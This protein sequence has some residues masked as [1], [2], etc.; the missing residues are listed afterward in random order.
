MW[1]GVFVAAF[2]RKKS[3]Y[4]P[5]ILGAKASLY[6]IAVLSFVSYPFQTA[7]IYLHFIICL[8]IIFHKKHTSDFAV[9]PKLQW[10]CTVAGTITLALGFINLHGYKLQREGQ[11]LVFEGRIDVGIEKYKEAYPILK[12]N[13]IFLFYYGSALALKGQYDESSELLEQSIRKTSNPNG[14]ILLGN[15][16]RKQGKY[17]EAESAYKNVI[18]QIPSKLYSKYRLVQLLLEQGRESEARQWANEI[19]ATK[20][21]VPTTAAKEIKEEMRKLLQYESVDK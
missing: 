8:A 18:Y 12:D 11:K 15:N 20:E 16:Y 7:L 4:S 2:R 19:L 6:A 5:F 21:K 1:A 17:N 9:F 13:G 10:I 14:Y 3:P